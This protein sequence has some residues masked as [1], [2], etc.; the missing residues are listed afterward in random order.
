MHK[1]KSIV[2]FVVLTAFLVPNFSI[3][4]TNP[5]SGIEARVREYFSDVPD[6]IT[7][8]KCESGF[9]Q[10]NADGSAFFDRSG[11]YI[12][13]FQIAYNIHAGS[14][15]YEGMD[16][17][18][19]EG[20]MAYA[21]KLYNGKGTEPWK[22]CLKAPSATATPVGVA[23]NLTAN[24]NIGMTNP[25]VQILQKILNKKGFIIAAS[26]PGS[27]GN[28]TNYF[29][30]LTKEAVKKFQCSKNIVCSGSESTTGFGG[31]GPMTRAALNQ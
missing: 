27:Q 8:A 1:S 26:G 2:L 16:L 29:G 14:A 30:S 13:V 21:R 4:Q 17:K 12:G 19:L 25:Q 28:E 3:G 10:Y 6:M 24:L 9:Q 11:T 15:I 5:N 7:I 31:V 20:N 22:G 18:T 23:G